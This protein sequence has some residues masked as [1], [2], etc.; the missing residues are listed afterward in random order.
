MQN[1]NRLFIRHGFLVEEI[2]EGR[3]DCRKETEENMTFL[4][5]TLDELFVAYSFGHGILRIEEKELDEERWLLAVDVSYRGRTE[6]LQFGPGVDI[7]GIKHFDT[8]MAGIIR[9]LNRV[10]LSTTSCCDGH[11]K[12]LPAIS[13]TRDTD[14]ETGGKVLTA[15]GLPKIHVRNH[16][17]SIRVPRIQLLDAAEALSTFSPEDLEKGIE[18]LKKR[19]FLMELE[20]SLSIDGESGEEDDIRDWVRSKLVNHVDSL[21]V[22]SKGNILAVKVYGKGRGPVIL[23]NAHLDTVCSFEEG[24]EIIKDGNIWTSSSG[25]LGADDRAGVAILLETLKRLDATNFHGTVKC[26]FTVEEEI[27]LLGA[28]GVDADFLHDVDAAFV[29]DRRGTGDI[30]TSCG[31]YEKFCDE[32]F[33]EFIEEIASSHGLPGWKCTAG[34]SSD[35]RILA[36]HGIQSVNL[37]AGY[38]HEHSSD[39]YLDVEGCLGTVELLMAIFKEARTMRRVVRKGERDYKVLR[40]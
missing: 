31:G 15:I 27:G 7:P 32:S 6:M 22:D 17:V 5:E 30:V 29:I 14:M 1:L 2:G 25:I 24:R 8:Y 40:A 11:E 36:T 9:Q 26:I 20:R 3:F 19:S 39:E 10:G 4:L 35:T 28:K 21:E 18:E 33:G 13:F 12:K 23:L 34:G 38:Y 16:S 37:S